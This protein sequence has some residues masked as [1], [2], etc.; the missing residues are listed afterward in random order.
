MYRMAV[1]MIAA[2]IGSKEE[3]VRKV[4]VR[5]SSFSGGKGQKRLF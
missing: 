5:V 4:G 1:D 3:Y 2:L